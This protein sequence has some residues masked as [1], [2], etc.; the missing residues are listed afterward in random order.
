MDARTQSLIFTIISITTFLFTLVPVR[1]A[2]LPSDDEVSGIVKAC[3]GGRFQQIEG[4]IEGKISIWKR[5]AVASGKASKEYLGAILKTVPQ[6]EQISPENY[7][8]YTDCII[9][10]L[11][12]YLSAAAPSERPWVSAEFLR[13]IEPLAFGSLR[14]AHVGDIDTPGAR[15]GVM[16]SLTNGGNSPAIKAFVAF[17][18]MIRPFNPIDTVGNTKLIHDICTKERLATLED[19]GG[20]LIFRDKT[21]QMTFYG[22]TPSNTFITDSNGNVMAWIVTCIGYYDQFEAFHVLGGINSFITKD[23]RR[24]F[25]PEGTID[26]LLQNSMFPVMYDLP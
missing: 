5:N 1:S 3:A 2:A 21:V 14:G 22:G 19:I 13:I 11:S 18:L 23:G 15:I 4:D 17:A 8:T 25:K 12:K 24:S 20:V 6:N 16:F 7:K 26:G 9:N 10:A